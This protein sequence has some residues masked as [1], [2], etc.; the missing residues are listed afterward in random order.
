MLNLF[1]TPRRGSSGVL[2]SVKLELQLPATFPAKYAEPLRR[3]MEQCSVRRAID[4]HLS[5][6]TRMFALS[7]PRR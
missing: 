4:A 3:I 6:P 1:L 5:F 2:A 7:E